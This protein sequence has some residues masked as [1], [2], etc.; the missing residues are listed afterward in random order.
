[1]SELKKI[2]FNGKVFYV[3]P[4]L[5][6]L[7][8]VEN[9]HNSYSFEE[10]CDIRQQQVVNNQFVQSASSGCGRCLLKGACEL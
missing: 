10:Y 3:D 9:P 5:Q 6:E 7:R 1:M 8:Q 4:V 2:W